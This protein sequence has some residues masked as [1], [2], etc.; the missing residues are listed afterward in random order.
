MTHPH[1]L[2][3]AGLALAAAASFGLAS[4]LQHLEAGRVDKRGALDP[5]LLTALARRPIW[6][7]GIVA[8]VLAVVLQAV[9]LHFGAVALVQPLL[10]AGLPVAVLLSARY[11]GRAL[12]GKERLGLLLCTGGL[13]L[14]APATAT[15]SLG[16]APSRATATIAGVLLGAAAGALLL[17]AH[18]V[19]RLAP[20]A[21]GTAAGA[22]IGAGS[23]LLAVSAGRTGDIPA[24]LGSVA[25]YA[26]LV[27]GLLGLLLSQAAF[28]TGAL[29]APLAAL[30]VVE[31]VVAVL[32]AVTVLHERLPSGAADRAAAVA[33]ALLA[34]AGVV[35]L[36]RD[37]PVRAELAR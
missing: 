23:V 35:A 7:L 32:L 34:V 21:T 13:L 25:P 29:G 31:P 19:P 24:L 12:L 5:G 2:L 9:A 33:G 11:A 14:L 10:V 27:V 37:E 28:Q 22:V 30:S 26:A 18:R 3:A 17:L 20:P 1:P 15:T 4:A 6:L 36:T 8:D 16:I